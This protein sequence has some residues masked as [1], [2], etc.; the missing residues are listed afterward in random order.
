MTELNALL[1]ISR[2]STARTLVKYADHRRPGQ[3][4]NRRL[5]ATIR[6][7]RPKAHGDYRS[8]GHESVPR[9][10]A[11]ASTV[12]ELEAVVRGAVGSSDLM[13]F[14]RMDA[15]Q[16]LNRAHGGRGPK[17]LAWWLGT[18]SS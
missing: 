3:K 17:M 15:G 18:L 13:E 7:D 10:V 9:A 4:A 16:V 14:I 6:R 11:S 2:T 5:A 12:S 1:L 8:S